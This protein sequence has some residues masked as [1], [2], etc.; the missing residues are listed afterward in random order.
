VSQI[1]AE[2]LSNADQFLGWSH[3]R[4]YQ[5][6]TGVP[7]SLLAALFM[8]LESSETYEYVPATREDNAVGIAAGAYLAGRK[9][10]VLMQNSGLGVCYNA[11]ASLNDI[12]AIPT[13]IVVSWRGEGGKD[14]PEHIRM[15]K[16]MMRMLDDLE[17]P[18]AVAQQTTLKTQLEELDT[19]STERK[20]PAALIIPKGLFA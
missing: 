19:Q 1:S 6:Y 20:R 18:W 17:I 2:A 12:Y 13:L 14:A 8:R 16:V 10:M 9:T 11:L 7:C 15:G 4:G 5:F 3:S